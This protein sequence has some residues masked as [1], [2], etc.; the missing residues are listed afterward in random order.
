MPRNTKVYRCVN[1][2]KRKHKYG[3]AI[4]ICQKS[5]KQNYMSGKRIG[6]ETK[7]RKNKRNLTKKNK[8]R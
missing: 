6:K 7:R 5:T 2:L 8:Y 3:I 1:K 4:A